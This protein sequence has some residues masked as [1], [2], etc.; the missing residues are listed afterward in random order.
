VKFKLLESRQSDLED[1]Y[2]EH[3]DTIKRL[4]AGDPSGNQK[5]LKWAFETSQKNWIDVS[6]MIEFIKDFHKNHN[7]FTPEEKQLKST[8]LETYNHLQNKIAEISRERN[9]KDVQGEKENDITL[10]LDNEECIVLIPESH[11]ASIKYG[12]NT[13]WCTT[14][15]D[16]AEYNHYM[17]TGG[18]YYIMNKSEKFE[19]PKVAVHVSKFS[20]QITKAFEPTDDTIFD[21]NLSEF[22]DSFDEIPESA[23]KVIVSHHSEKFKGE[24]KYTSAGEEDFIEA[25]REYFFQSQY[26]DIGEN[27]YKVDQRDAGKEYDIDVANED[28]DE[29]NHFQDGGEYNQYNIKFIRSADEDE[30]TTLDSDGGD[31][32]YNG[33]LFRVTDY[34]SDSSGGWY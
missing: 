16:P 13:K 17:R 29:E 32:V 11:E 19:Y 5:Y 23:K 24:I 14:S 15:P 1:Q 12:R 18:L 4:A 3:V 9:E 25:L 30:E 31:I 28:V 6:E 20:R 2:P 7:K 26:G 33:K 22:A 8:D 21:R 27:Q 34:D 10:L